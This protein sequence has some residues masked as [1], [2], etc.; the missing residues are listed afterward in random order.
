MSTLTLDLRLRLSRFLGYEIPPAPGPLDFSTDNRGLT[1]FTQ[2]FPLAYPQ[3]AVGIGFQ[4]T[5]TPVFTVTYA[6]TSLTVYPILNPTEGVG[7][8]IAVGKALTVGTG[9]LVIT[10]TGG[11]FGGLFGRINEVNYDYDV[12]WNS[13]AQGTAASSPTLTAPSGEL[14]AVSTLRGNRANPAWLTPLPRSTWGRVNNADPTLAAVVSLGRGMQVQTQSINNGNVPYAL[15]ALSLTP[16]VFSPLDL[17]NLALWYDASDTASI[18]QVGGLVSQ[19]N[20]KS[21]N[22]L[23]AVQPTGS[24]QMTTGAATV[25][26]RNVLTN[27]S[28]YMNIPSGA[29][30]IPAGAH[31]TFLVYTSNSATATSRP[32]G[33]EA[34]ATLRYGFS[35]NEFGGTEF[36]VYG[37]GYAT[38][39]ASGTLTPMIY[40]LRRS[41]TSLRA[42]RGDGVSNSNT[43]GADVTL[44]GMW[45][46]RMLSS[47]S[48][49][50]GQYLEVIAYKDLKSVADMNTIGNALAT[51]WGLTWPTIST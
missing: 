25:N 49:Y 10:C 16:H 13:N 50:A 36:R 22:G 45:L 48:G 40:A 41:G 11:T 19:L 17:P 23:H 37:S 28:G 35:L 38:V 32:F 1:T 42:N 27:T 7:S 2:S 29:Y 44:D 3:A 47:G 15:Q 4:Y 43:S 8:L 14:L 12:Q 18:S 31:T 9:N 33:G 34:A 51:K 39:T 46:G 20:D 30:T 21:G 6:G 24:L 5:G 26:G